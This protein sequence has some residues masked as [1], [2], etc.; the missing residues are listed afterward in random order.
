VST[1]R[2]ADQLEMIWNNAGRALSFQSQH[3]TDANGRT[4][5]DSGRQLGRMT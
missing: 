3:M 5:C 4:H 2:V 1:F